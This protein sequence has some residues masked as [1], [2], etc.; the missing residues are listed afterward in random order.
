[1]KNFLIAFSI[2]FLVVMFARAGQQ[3]IEEKSTIFQDVLYRVDTD[4]PAHLKGAKIIVR[5]ADGRESIVPAERFKVV[6]RR[7]QFLAGKNEITSKSK[8]CKL[9]DKKNIVYVG[10]KRELGDLETKVSGNTAKVESK[11]TLTPSV[12]YIRR[13]VL[14]SDLNVGGGV[15][16]N[17]QVQ[18]T[19]GLE[20]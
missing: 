2:F 1:M 9:D 18:G 16:K 5:L 14:N 17:G 15:D 11:R 10:A 13:K 19:L 7:Q 20:F 6:A 3:C 4:M 8:K 12:N